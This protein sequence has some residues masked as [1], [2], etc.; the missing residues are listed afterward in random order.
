MKQDEYLP[1]YVLP[2]SAIGMGISTYHYLIQRGI[3]THPATCSVGI[4]CDLSN[5]NYFGFVT[6]PF[7]ALM[8]FTMITVIMTITKWAYAQ[9][10]GL[11]T[12]E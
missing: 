11:I 10:D 9:G 1:D 7:M 3:F 6:I 12:E 8:A 5:V 2:F 4:P